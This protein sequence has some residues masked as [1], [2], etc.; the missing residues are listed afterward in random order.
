MKPSL[1]HLIILT[2]V[3]LL[4]LSLAACSRS[5]DLTSTNT[6]A[7][8]SIGQPPEY[9]TAKWSQPVQTAGTTCTWKFE[10]LV[11]VVL[12]QQNR[13]VEINYTITDNAPTWTDAQISACL[14]ANGAGWTRHP[15]NPKN[16][17]S[18]EGTNAV[19]TGPSMD[20]SSKPD[21]TELIRQTNNIPRF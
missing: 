18:Q 2:A 11:A 5:S 20:I 12:F 1:S 9:F 6:A 13:A 14:A 3:A 16:W 21:L 19:L 10:N 8:Y 17:I 15:F 4:A 7:I